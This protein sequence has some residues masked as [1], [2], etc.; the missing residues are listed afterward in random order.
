MVCR[1]PGGKPA[2]PDLVPGGDEWDVCMSCVRPARIDTVPQH[3]GACHIKENQWPI[4]VFLD[5]HPIRYRCEWVV[6]SP[7]AEIV[8]AT[9]REKAHMIVMGTHGYGLLGR[10]LM[11]SVAQRVVADC[12]V[13]VLLVK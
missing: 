4:K 11:G 6:G 12:D 3:S 10:V 13:P 8:E 1:K 9:R 2:S 5:R 7:A